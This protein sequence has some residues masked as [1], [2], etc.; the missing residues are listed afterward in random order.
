MCAPSTRCE[1]GKLSRPSRTPE[2]ARS[3]RGSGSNG[4]RLSSWCRPLG[5]RA[6]PGATAQLR[7]SEVAAADGRM[8]HPLAQYTQISSP[9]PGRREPAPLADIHR[10]LQPATSSPRAFGLCVTSWRITRQPR[11]G[12]GWRPAPPIRQAPAAWQLDPRAPNVHTSPPGL[13]PV[14][15]T[16]RRC[17]QDRLVGDRRLVRASIPEPP[18]AR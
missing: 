11:H 10:P 18:L 8:M 14:H 13:C 15:R 7:W 12:A 1:S 5:G 4:A 6:D 17:T 2:Y 9:A 3:S 16:A